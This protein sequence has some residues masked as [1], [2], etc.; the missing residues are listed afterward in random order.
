MIN[1]NDTVSLMSAVE[2]SKTP[3]S[4]LLDTFFPIVPETAVTPTIEVQIKTGERRLAPFVIRGGKAVELKR[5]GFDDYFYKPPMMAPSRVIDPEMISDRGFG[6]GIYSTKTPAQRATEIQAR[7]LAD[8]QSAIVNRKNK[9]AGDLLTTGKYEIKG[10]ADDGK[11]TVADTVDFNF[12]QKIVPT[13]TWDKAGATIYSDI[14]S[15]SEKIQEAS[16]MVPTVMIVGKN[17]AGYMLGNDQ[18]MK[19]MGI[20]STAN[21]SMFNFAP[22]ITSPQVAFVGRIP[23]LNLEVYTYAES[24]MD[25]DGK[26][27]GFIGDDD[28]IIGIPGRGRQYHGA[29][30]LLNDAGMGYNTFV[31]PY[32]PYYSGNKESQELRLTMYS[33]CLIAPECITDFAVIKSKGE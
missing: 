9:M 25:D 1:L 28:V 16:G 21:L 14:K 23:A 32:V 29:V 3:A 7:D 10:Y 12:T 22:R 30:T 33:R 8:L 17:V 19:W 24:Y 2:R 26:L 11:L 20:P 6:E 5:G 13:T 31:A 27:K 18:I 4:L 15:A